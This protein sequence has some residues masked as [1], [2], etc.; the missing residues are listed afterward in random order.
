MATDV[1]GLP[2]LI[3]GVAGF[4]GS[5]VA[6]A[7]L[8]RGQ[9]VVGVDN[10]DQFYSRQRKEANLARVRA[11]TASG[12]EFSFHEMDLTDRP[13]VAG[14]FCQ[15]FAGV[16]HLAAKANPRVSVGDPIGYVHANVYATA[17]VLE[18]ARQQFALDAGVCSRVVVASSSSV[19]GNCPT[20]PFHEGLDVT[21]PISPYAAT[22]QAC[23]V[24]GYTHWHLHR[25]P[26]AMLRFFTVYGPCQRPDL[27][28]S[29][30]IDRISTGTP[31]TLFGDGTM[32]RDCTYI[33]D[34]VS[35][36]L[37]AYDRIPAHGYRVWNLGNSTPISVNE[38]LATV[39]RVVGKAPVLVPGK[40]QP[41][42]VQLTYADL[43]RSRAELGYEPKTAFE[44]GVRKQVAWYLEERR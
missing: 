28:V 29:L 32:A 5:H 25:Q 12:A 30:F 41:G 38:M 18:H 9:A 33:D 1:H 24:M 20:P 7:L 34:V 39:A 19:Y 37:A 17:I 15:R 23:E 3:T 31:I 27:G 44:A 42:D 11:A 4:I 16:I 40:V 2:I 21:T 36:I 26:V 22:K 35:G 8:A 13:A 10:F 6:A 43:T 14:L